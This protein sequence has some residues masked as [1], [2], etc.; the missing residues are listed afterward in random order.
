MTS[1]TERL[2]RSY[3]A[4]LKLPSVA[5]LLAGMQ[6]ARIAQSMVAITIVLFALTVYNSPQLA[7]MAT[8]FSVFP[9][10]LVS[11][12]AGALLDRHG[13]TR[14]VT[15]DYIIALAALVLIG[16]LAISNALPAWLLI[17]IA[18]IASLTAPLSNTGLRSLFPI[19][20]PAHLWERVNAVDST[21]YVV[22]VIIG[23]PLAASLFAL[24]GGPVT[25]I[26][27]G[28]SYGL[29]ALIIARTPDPQTV[30]VST[31]RVVT[32]AWQGVIYTWRNR[33]LRG[34]GFSIS[35]LNLA[36]GAF[37]I[38]VPILVLNQLH[39]EKIVVGLVIAVQ[40]L[41]GVVSAFFF[42]RHD[43]R[44][45]E[46]AMLAYP[47]FGTAMTLALLF[48]KVNLGMLILVMAITGILNGP[49]DIALFTL[50]QRRTD[51]SWTG[52]AFAVS[53]A[54]NY[55]GVPIGSAIAGILAAQSS[56]P[57]IAFCVATSVASGAFAL[58]MIPAR[59]ER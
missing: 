6:L 56:T 13:R 28:L 46:R 8:F 55:A 37:T 18:G 51:P 9:G 10:L 2:D 38:L 16:A 34:L 47:M 5:R 24:W 59:E 58:L 1:P 32:D 15:L 4:L 27:I 29:A 7:G 44:N 11:P 25:F 36:N 23:P 45:R 41:T 48:F 31:G 40:G 20:I 12:I 17:L 53:M 26:I 50:R 52:R 42:G 14:L 54:F 39:F 3:R 57:A 30:T 35:T 43:S 19:I 22:A 33:T 49:I 21:G